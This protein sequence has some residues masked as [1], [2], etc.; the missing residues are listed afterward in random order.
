MEYFHFILSSIT[1]YFSW[2]IL[3]HPNSKVNKK[4]PVIKIKIIQLCPYLQLHIGKNT[5][6][7]H[8]WIFSTI[9]LIISITKVCGFLDSDLSR[10]FLTGTI[11]QGL[12]YPDWKHI[13]K[14]K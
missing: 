2:K 7:I 11:F 9:L 14:N 6:H 8:H 4:L 10:G 1:G 13:I 12:T 3:S 5:I